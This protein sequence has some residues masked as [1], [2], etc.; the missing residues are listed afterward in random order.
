MAWPQT[1]DYN[2][3]IQDPGRCF[4]DQDLARGSAAEGMMAGIPLSFAGSFATVYKVTG[5]DGRPW[6]VKCFT[7]KVD[8]LQLRYQRIAEHLE[9]HKRRFA[10]GFQYLQE[11]IKVGS[12]WFPVVKMQWVEGFTL[13]E[14]LRDRVGNTSLLEQLCGLWLRLG[15]EMAEDRMAHADLQ[16]GNVLLVPG[17]SSSSLLL[18]LVD[19]DG[20]WVPSLA[21]TPPNEVGHPNYQHPARLANGGYSPEI[22]RFSLLAVYTALRCLVV[23]GK[24]LWD[25]FDNGENLL[26]RE[27]DFKSPGKSKL[28]A[29]LLALPDPNA[30]ALA[31]RLLLAGQGPLDLVPPLAELLDGSDVAPLTGEQADR[32]RFEKEEGGRRQE[33]GEQRS[34]EDQ[35]RTAV[36]IHPSSFI[37]HPFHAVLPRPSEVLDALPAE[38]LR[39]RA[40]PIPLDSRPAPP[41]PP[42]PALGKAEGGRRKEETKPSSVHPSA[43]ILP[44]FPG[45][46][47]GPPGGQWKMPPPPKWLLALGLAEDGFLVRFWPV[48]LGA[49]AALPL[50]VLLVGAAWLLWPSAAPPVASGN[51]ETAKP[52]L[53]SP[54]PV[55]LR[56]GQ[57]HEATFVV[58]RGKTDGTLTVRVEGL[59]DDVSCEEG[60]LPAGQGPG[61][62][63]LRFRPDSRARAFNGE[64]QVGLF[65]GGEKLDERAVE[66]RVKAFIRPQLESVE[67]ILLEAGRSCLVLGK[68]EAN[69]N[70]DPWTLTVEGLPPG[71][72]QRPPRGAV[73]PGLAAV[74]LVAA[75]NA[76]PKEGRIVSVWLLAGGVRANSVLASLS[77]EKGDRE[78]AIGLELPADI[79]LRAGGK[80]SV[81]VT[82]L[83][84]GYR[85]PIRLDVEDLPRGVTALAVDVPE[86]AETAEIDLRVSD[87]APRL[88]LQSF[89]IVAK[90]EGKQVGS[91]DGRFLLDRAAEEKPPDNPG[92]AR[93]IPPA[94]EV[95]FQTADEATLHG[96]LYP[97]PVGLRGPCVLMVPE[98]SKTTSRKDASWVLLAQIL[99]KQGCSVLTFDFRGFGEN[100]KGQD[101]LPPT[102]WNFTANKVLLNHL[103]HVGAAP[104]G[105]PS[106]LDGTQF[107]DAYKPWLVQDIV[108]ARHF[109]DGKHDAVGLNSHN[110]VVIGA[111]EGATLACFWL[112]A[113]M[114]RT[115]NPGLPP[116]VA[117]KP[118]PEGRDVIA[119]VWIDASSRLGGDRLA[120]PLTQLRRQFQQEQA[121]RMFFL[122]DLKAG[123]YA[124]NRT[125]SDALRVRPEVLKPI[126]GK[127]AI[128]QALLNEQVTVKAVAAMLALLLNKR[129]LRGWES[130]GLRQSSY[131]W[132]LGNK[133]HLA[134]GAFAAGPMPLPLD[135]LGF[136]RLPA[137]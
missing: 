3:A 24:G 33:A 121:P 39:T 85:G 54:G 107:P 73:P 11:G 25:D 37:L 63:R 80:T 133:N 56:A 106:T 31:G 1:V 108:A 76:R 60:K 23:G 71:V 99:Q 47:P 13:N 53:L 88:A 132:S 67:P 116:A 41:P 125:M 126:E 28:F 137:R 104:L 128:G 93:R 98:P 77:I 30:S 92:M 103:K 118:K 69:G 20:M 52:H 124:R 44:P 49:V 66:L 74:E 122:Y 61:P 17:A 42:P 6:A 115:K 90:V 38:P 82:L 65:Q 100:R 27:S 110:L 84:N 120:V 102:F 57:D 113:E 14:F 123:G 4:Q 72:S 131:V 32:I 21:D 117:P 111:G 50:L 96:T 36:L 9:E 129:E 46:P 16:H 64:I 55:D 75:A 40:V 89:R 101:S 8:N 45:K 95:T 15:A 130:R 109:L 79:R 91:C 22:D 18:R 135:P 97:S 87:D 35:V 114:S 10:V 2:A 70:T 94:Q 7:R 81:R 83:R 136:P 86:G 105:N 127:G 112:G 29:R 26:F 58:D 51:E 134:K 19:Y 62:V 78:V 34:R 5:P 119:A 68:V 59:P 48:T 43:F 12:D